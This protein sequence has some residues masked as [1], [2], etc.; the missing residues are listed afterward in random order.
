MHQDLDGAVGTWSRARP[1]LTCVFFSGSGLIEF[2]LCCLW[3]WQ[4]PP[5]PPPPAHSLISSVQRD[6]SV[7]LRFALLVQFAHVSPAVL[8]FFAEK[9]IHCVCV[10]VCV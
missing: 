3:L 7:G 4:R 1:G 6:Q 5:P 8:P 9:M 2:S 10:C